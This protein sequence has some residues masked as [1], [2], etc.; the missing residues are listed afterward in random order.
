MEAIRILIADDHPVVREGLFAML[1][2]ESDFPWAFLEGSQ[3][4]AE[5]TLSRFRARRRAALV[6]LVVLPFVV[7]GRQVHGRRCPVRGRIPMN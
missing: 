7:Q 5:G 3:G 2:R 4:S 6:V 1:S